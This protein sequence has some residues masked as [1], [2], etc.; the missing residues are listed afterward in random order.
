[1]NE[2]HRRILRL[3]RLRSLGAAARHVWPDWSALRA[4]GRLGAL[5]LVASLAT[6]SIPATADP[7]A[8]PAP[9]KLAPTATEE[10]EPAHSSQWAPSA[11][12]EWVDR[13]ANARQRVL[14]AREAHDEVNG[15]YAKALYGNAGEAELEKLV[16]QRDRSRME[17]ALAQA[18]IPELV[19]R[20]RA[21]GVAS[22]T[23]AIY[24]RS[25][26]N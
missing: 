11:S 14:R 5:G 24:E 16:A 13:L 22:E 25:I 3:A 4:L 12:P 7:T 15:R 10:T 18:A 26:E 2:D 23:L 9:A 19:S 21:A 6:A 8:D 20:A 17:L 1:M